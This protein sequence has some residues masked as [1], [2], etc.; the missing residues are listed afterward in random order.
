MIIQGLC[1]TCG[2]SIE[3]IPIGDITDGYCDGC[4]KKHF[5]N[6]VVDKALQ[7]VKWKRQTANFATYM[8]TVFDKLPCPTRSQKALEWQYEARG[9]NLWGPPRTGKTRTLILILKQCFDSGKHFK[10]FGPKDFAL[11]L[12]QRRFNTADFL[13]ACRCVDVIAF[14]DIGK[15]QLTPVQEGEFFGL[16]EYFIASGRPWVVTHNYNGTQLEHRFPKHGA[17]IVARL[18]ECFTSIHFNQV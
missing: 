18:R 1:R 5:N 4:A 11:A 15:L 3:L 6:L 9:L 17:A 7:I 14:D 8:D 10:I 2:V 12:D 16:L 13:T